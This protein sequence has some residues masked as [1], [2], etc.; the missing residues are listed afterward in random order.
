MRRI[1]KIYYKMKNAIKHILTI[2]SLIIFMTANGFSQSVDLSGSR[3]VCFEK[4]DRLVLKSVSNDTELSYY[5]ISYPAF[6]YN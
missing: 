3:I 1:Y 6:S 2:V 4:K 5:L